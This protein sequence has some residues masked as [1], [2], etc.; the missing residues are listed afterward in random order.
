MILGCVV[1]IVGLAFLSFA[2]FII[3]RRKRNAGR[4][5]HSIYDC[6]ET[7]LTGSSMPTTQLEVIAWTIRFTAFHRQNSSLGSREDRN[8]QSTETS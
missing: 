6:H 7:T 1:V 8:V 5:H 4:S 2:I 3:K